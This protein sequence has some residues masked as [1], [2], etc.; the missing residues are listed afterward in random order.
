MFERPTATC[1][2]YLLSHVQEAE[3]T[4]TQFQENRILMSQPQQKI[5]SHGPFIPDVNMQGAHCIRTSV[6]V[7]ELLNHEKDFN[8]MW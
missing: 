3:N 7:L 2:T 4:I 5:H 1:R 6:G 8:K